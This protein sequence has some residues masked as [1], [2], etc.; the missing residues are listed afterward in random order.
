MEDRLKLC[1]G[2]WPDSQRREPHRIGGSDSDRVRVQDPGGAVQPWVRV[3]GFRV[4]GFWVREVADVIGA[5]VLGRFAMS[6]GC[7]G[8]VRLGVALLMLGLFSGVGGPVVAASDGFSDLGEAGVHEGAVRALAADGVFEGTGCGTGR[9]CPADPVERWVMAV[10]LVRVLDGGDPGGSGSSRFADV[11]ASLWWAPYVERLA[12]LGV[13]AGCATGPA[14]FCPRDSVSRAQMATF[15]VRAFGLA[16]GPDAGFVDVGGGVHAAGINALAASG[17]TSGCAT[18]PARFCPDR[19]V[20]RAQMSSFLNRSR[21]QPALSVLIT[22]THPDPVVGSFEVEIRFSQPVTDFTQGDLDVVNGTVTD[23]AGS[24]SSYRATI[25]PAADGT[26]V[27][28]IAESTVGQPDAGNLGSGLFTR[29]HASDGTAGGPGIDTW[30]R[31]AVIEAYAA[32]FQRTEPDPGYTGNTSECVA[33][34]TSQEY[35]DSVVRRVNW[36]RQMAGL[37]A[38]AEREQYSQAAQ[39]TALMMSAE[40]ALSHHPDQNWACYTARGAAT[41]A[42]SNLGLGSAGVSGIDG[43]MQ[44]SGLHNISVGHRRWILYP[45]LREVGTGNIPA[46]RR[47][48][49]LHVQD[50]HTR[51][52]RPDVREERGFVAWPPSGYIPARTLWGRWSFTLPNADFGAA[53]VEVTNDHGPVQ[54]QI[55]TRAG[56]LERGIVWAVDGRTDSQPLSQPTDGDLCYTI[57]I[58]N[59][60]VAGA[61][62]TPFQYAT[63]V[64][65]LTAHT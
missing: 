10:W 16:S 15:L 52:T 56:F 32:E 31:A 25:R 20:T 7:G 29:T 24:G 60:Y 46:G 4:L 47:A 55:L 5:T 12:D 63:C 6:H 65:D 40:G 62:Q 39:Q 48:N 1:V 34:E 3:R 50:D 14:R 18:G 21:N 36:Y 38:V 37:P 22:S 8:V 61:K 42:L 23:M 53:T 51:S 28:R 26:I 49:A 44:D 19:D 27:V 43:Y 54:V 58:S 11:D 57:T 2:R 30:S 41:A 33:G 9:F 64:L 35:R 59:V 17:V 13:T 45:Q